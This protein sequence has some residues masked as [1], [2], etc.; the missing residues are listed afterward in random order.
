MTEPEVKYVKLHFRLEIEDDWP[1][2]GVENLWAVDQGDG[3]VKLDNVPW[4]ARGIACGDVL[5]ASPDEVGVLWA[6]DVVRPSEN[7]TIRLIVF[8]DGGSGA[9]RQSVLDA[10]RQLGVGGEGIERFGMVALD[11]P[12]TADLAQVQRLL[13]HGVAKEWWDM[14]EGC[15][16]AQW[17]ALATS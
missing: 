11:V 6:G 8:R 10:F 7:C 4:F 17:R 13:D 5:A 9:A 1:P 12:P 14:E 15:V 3:T 2:A 16:T